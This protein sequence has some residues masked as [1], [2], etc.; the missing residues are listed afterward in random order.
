MA[1][2][3]FKVSNDTYTKEEITAL[4]IK[5]DQLLNEYHDICTIASEVK[6]HNKIW[7]TKMTNALHAYDEANNLYWHAKRNE[8]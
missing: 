6:D 2:H 7:R 1:L 8:S 3:L 4:R 5:R